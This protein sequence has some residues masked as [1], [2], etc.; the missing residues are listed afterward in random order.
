MIDGDNK[1][2]G[3]NPAT[4]IREPTVDVQL[5]ETWKNKYLKRKLC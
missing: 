3:C 4:A 1:P 2:A 5:A